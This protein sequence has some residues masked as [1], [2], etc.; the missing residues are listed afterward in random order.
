MILTRVSPVPVDTLTDTKGMC[1]KNSG[2]MQE[3]KWNDQGKSVW[4]WWGQGYN[5]KQGTVGKSLSTQKVVWLYPLSSEE[6]LQVLRKGNKMIC[7][8]FRKNSIA[9]KTFSS[10]IHD[11]ETLQ[12]TQTSFSGWMDESVNETVVYPCNGI[13]LSSK[14][15]KLVTHITIWMN[16]KWKLKR[17]Q[18]HL[19]RIL[20][21]T[22]Y[23]VKKN[24][25][26]SA[27]A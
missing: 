2:R 1:L 4:W 3:W 25:S 7:L 19:C 22:N 9:V 15:K 12:I 27:R 24:R 10:F 11:C 18:F 16:A 6:P 13:V 17:L 26:A 5:I 23:I 14:N 20:E 8:D 21:K